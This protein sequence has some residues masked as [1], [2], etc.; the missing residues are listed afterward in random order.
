[1]PYTIIQRAAQDV[2]DRL[3]DVT[4]SAADEMARV[5]PEYAEL[6]R[7]F[8]ADVVRE[9]AVIIA[10]AIRDQRMLSDADQASLRRIGAE[11]ARIGIDLEGPLHA[12]S[13]VAQLIWSTQEAYAREAGATTEEIL[14]A[15][16]HLWQLSDA[17]GHEFVGGH[18]EAELVLSSREYQQRVDLVRSVLVG[19]TDPAQAGDKFVA[20]ELD[21]DERY[22][23]FCARP[24]R[25]GSLVGLE[26]EL[27]ASGLAVV[28]VPHEH[29]LIGLL[30]GE[31]GPVSGIVG[32]EWCK[33]LADAPVAFRRASRALDAAARLGRPGAHTISSLGI[34]SAITADCDLGDALVERYIEPLRTGRRYEADVEE[35]VAAYLDSGQRLDET[36]KALHLHPN[37]MRQRL[38]RF[39]ELTGADL[40]EPTDHLGAWWAF[41]VR[42]RQS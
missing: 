19:D 4:L 2:L 6:P 25:L 39:A 15:Q 32:M 29:D 7:V 3:D 40:S 13:A 23:V 14:A 42:D 11:Q 1:M 20:L 10:S 37:T 34:W 8:L 28:V 5:V 26:Q 21:P 17:T 27:D 18:R 30:S 36:A 12:L 33:C 22:L 9:P 38:R 24:Q 35:S 41:Q 16:L 31:P